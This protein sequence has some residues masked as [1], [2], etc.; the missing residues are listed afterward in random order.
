MLDYSLLVNIENEWKK[1]GSKIGGLHNMAL[2]LS[3]RNS[4]TVKKLFIDFLQGNITEENT[5]E[6]SFMWPNS[7]FKIIVEI[8]EKI[9]LDSPARL[10]IS[11][12][13][14]SSVFQ[15]KNDFT[16]LIFQKASKL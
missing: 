6:I 13:G 5:S 11:A 7:T 8:D 15:E 3:A 1:R 14:N 9:K 4:E 12:L 2:R 16:R 10:E